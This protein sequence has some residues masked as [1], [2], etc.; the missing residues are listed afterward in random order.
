MIEKI[1]MWLQEKRYRFEKYLKK[2]K[3]KYAW[4]YIT[5]GYDATDVNYEF[6]SFSDKKAK[7]YFEKRAKNAKQWH[8]FEI[9]YEKMGIYSN[10]YSSY[11]KKCPCRKSLVPLSLIGYNCDSYL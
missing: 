2:R 4:F 8:N 1:K 10:K 5:E 3:V 6:V 7:E 11:M 9:C